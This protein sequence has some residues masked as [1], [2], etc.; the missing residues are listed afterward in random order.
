MKKMRLTALAL[1]LAAASFSAHALFGDDDA[2]RAILDLRQRLDASITAQNRMAEEQEQTRRVMQ[3]MQNQIVTLSNEVAQLRGM[4]EQAQRDLE[5]QQQAMQGM[6]D[7]LRKAEASEQLS[8][9]SSDGEVAGGASFNPNAPVNSVAADQSRTATDVAERKE[10][11]A[12]ME[13]FRAGDYRGAQ[14]RLARFIKKH[15][16]S[17]Y[18]PSALFWL[19]NAQYATRNYKEAI[20]NFRSLLTNAPRH[21]KASEALLAIANCQIELKDKRAARESLNQLI[22][23]YPRTEAAQAGRE[24]LARLR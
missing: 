18:A 3:E 7:R 19:G 15:P 12:A 5:R 4:Q 22:K 9:E 21:D 1:S 17:S 6:E 10:Y 13:V 11:D 20:T 24:Q 2:R 16:Q 8:A 23:T 14:T